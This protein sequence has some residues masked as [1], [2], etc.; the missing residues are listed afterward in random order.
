MMMMMM[1]M[2]LLL[3]MMMMMTIMTMQLLLLLMMM[4]MTIMTMQLLLLLLLMM[5]MCVLN[6]I[7]TC[8]PSQTVL[9]PRMIQN[10]ITSSTR[11]VEMVTI[12][13]QCLSAV[14]HAGKRLQ[15]AWCTFYTQV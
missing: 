15:N 5:M 2:L 11:I 8:I 10:C 12:P 14:I 7:Y 1:I 13:R 9:E 3:L 4:I 6:R